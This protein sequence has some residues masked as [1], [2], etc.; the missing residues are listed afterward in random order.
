[1]N[2]PA[3][4]F[5]VAVAAGAGWAITAL[6]NS[7]RP[8]VIARQLS[9]QPAADP[10]RIVSLYAEALR[11]DSASPYRWADLGDAFTLDNQVPAASYCF[12]HA[13]ALNRRLP[14]IWLRDANFHFQTGTDAAALKSAVRVLQ[15]VPDYDGVL[16][17]YFDRMIG[18]PSQVLAEIGQ[19]RRAAVS[20]ASHLIATEQVDD[21]RTAWQA[22]VASGMA[23]K[24]LAASYVGLLLRAHRYAAAKADWT[25]FAGVPRDPPNLLFNG[26]FEDDPSGAAL[27]WRI[28][29]SDQFET[30]IDNTVAHDGKRSLHVRFLANANVSYA[31]L[32]QLVVVPPGS[33]ELRA[34]VRSSG[35][36]TNECPRLE[37]LDPELPARLDLR[38][39]PFCGSSDW[40]LVTQHVTVPAA[41]P[42]LAIRVIRL[43]SEKFD[44][45][46]AGTFW[47]D[48]V[49]LVPY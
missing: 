3:A 44:N 40:T 32:T 5:S 46:I 37:I 2:L 42:L 25:D 29:P 35:I 38:T 22:L 47:L 9:L 41:A 7:T 17:N 12:E 14:Q 13:L 48:S 30:A 21:A 1:M 23:D 8:D 49:Q 27:D 20:Y 6:D 33:Y 26:G 28:Q 45:K 10:A 11:R 4:I 24:P 36:T 15:T 43:A 16:F 31:N 18:N 39:E 34:W 19:N